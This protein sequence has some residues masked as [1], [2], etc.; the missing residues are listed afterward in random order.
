[1]P[2]TRCVNSAINVTRSV[3]LRYDRAA[4]CLIDKTVPFC[5]GARVRVPQIYKALGQAVSNLR[6][7]SDL[8]QQELADAIG[9]SRASVANIE[10]GEQRVFFDQVASISAYFSLKGIDE[11]LSF[12]Q[13]EQA[14]SAGKVQLSGDRLRRDLKREV[15]DLIDELLTADK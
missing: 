15:R 9:I 1:M 12:A 3:R 10:R 14:P 4:V 8:T 7:K 11:L 5:Y 13:A 2:L 6:R